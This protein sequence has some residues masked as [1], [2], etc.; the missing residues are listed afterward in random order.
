[1]VHGNGAGSAH[2]AAGGNGHSYWF[3]STK[4]VMEAAGVEC[5]T[6]DFPDPAQARAK[7][8]LPFIRDVLKVSE[9]DIV[10]GHSSGALAA[11]R[12]AETQRLR[13]LVV[14][15]GYHT[16]LGY[17]SERATG[18]FDKP[19]Q[20]S[21]IKANVSVRGQFASSDDPWI[22]VAEPRYIHKQLD[23]DYQEF[24]TDGHFIGSLEEPRTEFPAL[25]DYLLQ[26]FN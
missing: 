9:T 7:I 10:V 4:K 21:D 8:W 23:T 1:M 18:Y 25:V 16:D 15:S 6:P 12:L 17:E 26:E 3:P 24:S 5:I 19:W 22:P 11:M 14:V 13:G 2:E 20:W